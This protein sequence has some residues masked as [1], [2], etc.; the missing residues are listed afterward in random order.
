[1]GDQR[2]IDVIRKSDAA[3]L[4]KGLGVL[5]GQE[6]EPDAHTD[7][8][9]KRAFALDAGEHVL[10]HLIEEHRLELLGG[11]LGAGIAGTPGA[12]Q[13]RGRIAIAGESLCDDGGGGR[14]HVTSSLC[15]PG[16]R[17]RP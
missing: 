16:W 17:R 8:A 13:Y 15:S 5:L 11:T 2:T 3:G 9:A 6:R 10:E 7:A 14:R 4:G 12:A 1:M